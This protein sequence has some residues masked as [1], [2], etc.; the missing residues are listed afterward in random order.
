VKTVKPPASAVG[1]AEEL[2]GLRRR[3]GEIND[4]L[5]AAARRVEVSRRDVATFGAPAPK[6]LSL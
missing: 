4:T 2:A 5:T 3:Q 1:P 6:S